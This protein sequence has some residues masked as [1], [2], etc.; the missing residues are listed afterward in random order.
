MLFA[1]AITFAIHDAK[2]AHD[3]VEKWY[4]RSHLFLLTYWVS[5]D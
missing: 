4:F 2:I 1:M 5:G 3:F